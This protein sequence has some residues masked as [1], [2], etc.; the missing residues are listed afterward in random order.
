M[1]RSLSVALAICT[2]IAASQ[3][4]FAQAQ[5]I[6]LPLLSQEQAAQVG[7]KRAWVAQVPLD[8]ARSKITHIKIQAGL[9]PIVTSES[10]LYAMEAESGQIFWPF[11]IGQRRFNA[12]SASANASYVTVANTARLFVLDRA[13]GNIVLDRQVT[14]TPER[15]PALTA[16]EVILPLVQGG[17]EMYSLSKVKSAQLP[18]N[19]YPSYQPS[20][21]TLAGEL[22]TSDLAV[23][24]A[25]DLNQ[26]HVCLYGEKA[27][28]F[29]KVVPEGITST[30]TL[31][32]PQVYVG[33]EAGYVIAYYNDIATVDAAAKS[34]QPGSLH[35]L[36]DEVW[37]FSAGAPIHQRPMVTNTAVYAITEDGGMYALR[38]DTGE[39]IWFAPDPVQFV[40]I[41]PTRIYTLDQ[42]KRLTILDVK[43]GARV[44]AMPLPQSLKALRNDQSDRLVLYTED[45]LIQTLEEPALTQPYLNTPPKLEPPK[46]GA[47]KPTAAPADGAAPA[48]GSAPAAAADQ[49]AGG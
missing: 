45:G 48:A 41:S 8:R 47:T 49:P 4:Q 5:S 11:R 33:T 18:E 32:G 10:M 6:G 28:E 38:P 25:G 35:L 42:Y 36:G 46:K 21:G 26:F 19:I 24:W 27:S 9:L 2:W 43:T 23:A 39:V 40:S 29:N 14:G 7:L 37:R 22:N 12:L 17:L 13:T 3:F 44:D 34:G 15:G 20:A 31:F 30:P 1:A 16:D